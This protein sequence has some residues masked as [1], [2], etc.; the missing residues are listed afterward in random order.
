MKNNIIILHGWGL[1]GSKYSQ[2]SKILEEKGYKVYSPDLPGFGHEPLK[3]K[4]MT[5]SDYVDFLDN[6]IKSNDIKKPI[7]IA[8]SFG[9]RVAVKYCWKYPDNVSKLVLTG[10]PVVRERSFKKKIAFLG[11]M[12]G[13]RVLTLFPANLKNKF[14]KVLYFAIREWDYYKSGNLKDVFKNI[15]GEDLV[16]YAKE[17]KIP[18]ILVWGKEDKI[19]P[20]SLIPKIKKICP[21]FKS[22]V[23]ENYGHKLPYEN[24]PL[25][26]NSIESFL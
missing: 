21:D 19:T 20:V 4:S 18:T 16:S 26:F 24:P 12:V 22:A 23:I 10:V 9:G 5:L 14:R 11:A 1:N 17:I 2:L 8:H 25:F 15:I 6:F 7:L 3:S 13:G